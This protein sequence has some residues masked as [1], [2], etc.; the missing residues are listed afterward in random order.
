MSSFLSSDLAEE[1]R[2]C[3][4][5]HLVECDDCRGEL[6]LLVRMLDEEV[7]PDELVILNR[8]ETVRAGRHTVPVQTPGLYDRFCQSIMAGWKLAVVA[9][10]ILIVTTT[11]LLSLKNNIVDISP[12]GA[13]SVR[14]LEARLSS[15]P[16]S[17][18]LQIRTA[19][20]IGNMPPGTDELKR[21][22][23]N[24]FAMG[25]FYLQHDEFEK[26][27]AQLENAKRQEPGSV[28]ISNDLGVAYMESGLDGNLDKAAGQFKEALR[29]NPRYEPAVFNLALAYERLGH[30]SE[31]EEDFSL[32]LQI[33]PDSGWAKEVK[34]K[35]QLWKR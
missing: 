17:Q 19:R 1:E 33:D 25:R 28:E 3:C 29:L 15:Q 21:L 10:S 32:Y 18:F 24:S 9:A 11:F 23:A 5:R 26:A 22:G 35:L 7:S 27:I 14:T 30:F 12:Q 2:A 13:G 20:A 16:Y 31:A 6:A 34:S 4:Q 8:V